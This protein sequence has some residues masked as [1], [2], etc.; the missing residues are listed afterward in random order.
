MANLCVDISERYRSIEMSVSEFKKK[1]DLFSCS[2]R[3]DASLRQQAHQQM[4]IIKKEIS[5]FQELLRPYKIIEFYGQRLCTGQ[6]LA[7]QKLLDEV[8]EIRTESHSG[9]GSDRVVEMEWLMQYLTVERGRIRSISLS[10]LH[11]S[12]VPHAIN[13]LRYLNRL[14]LSQNKI[15]E[16]ENLEG[17]ES[18]ELVNL[19]DN[20][21]ETLTGLESLKNLKQLIVSKNDIQE[22]AHLENLSQLTRL[23]IDQN[24]SIWNLS[25]LAPLV[26]LEELSLSETSISTL[27]GIERIRALKRLFLDFTPIAKLDELQAMTQLETVSLCGTKVQSVAPLANCRNLKE[28]YLRNSKFNRLLELDPFDFLEALSISGCTLAFSKITTKKL[29][30]WR[31]KLK[32]RFIEK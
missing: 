15:E 31:D 32:S 9:R 30:Y 7:V 14:D 21:L 24:Y 3:N 26:N 27:A 1:Y 10:S 18:L 19:R 8:N 12:R 11:L 16:I 20:S 6:S 5:A 2:T 17:L 29:R 13:G 25:G 22:I 4:G 28:L 23:V